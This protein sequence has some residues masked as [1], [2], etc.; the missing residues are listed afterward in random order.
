MRSHI[1]FLCLSV[2]IADDQVSYLSENRDF[3]GF[4]QLP[5]LP[6]IAYDVH[7]VLVYLPTVSQ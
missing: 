3:T 1:Q 5:L 4:P 2:L 7:I 6:Q